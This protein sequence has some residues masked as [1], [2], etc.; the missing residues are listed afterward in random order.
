MLRVR[1]K[2]S[3]SFYLFVYG[4]QVLHERLR[5]SFYKDEEMKICLK[6][7]TNPSGT[8]DK[9]FENKLERNVARRSFIKSAVVAGLAIAGGATVAKKAAEVV[10][11]EDN[12]KFYRTDELGFERTWKDKELSLMSKEEKKEMLSNLLASSTSAKK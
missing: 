3:A 7:E 10:L 1:K 11:K 2:K 8:V 5:E 9:N 12:R 6:P 4:S